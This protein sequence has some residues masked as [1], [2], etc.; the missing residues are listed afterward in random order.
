MKNGSCY[1]RVIEEA[2]TMMRESGN[3]MAEGNRAALLT[4]LSVGYGRHPS[5]SAP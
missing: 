1:G 5:N 3:D 2:T 4:L